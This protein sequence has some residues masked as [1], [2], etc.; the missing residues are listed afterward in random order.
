[1]QLV[2][3]I[4]GTPHRYLSPNRKNGTTPA[5][6]KKLI[7]AHASQVKKARGK[8]AKHTE[9]HEGLGLFRG[10]IKAYFP[11]TDI[12]LEWMVAWEKGHRIMDKDNLINMLKPYQDG[13]AD[14]LGI[15]DKHFTS[16]IH[17]QYRDPDGTGYLRLIITPR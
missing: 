1:M 12:H 6:R 17:S 2:V 16:E 5:A 9:E 8:A 3:D 11:N 13:V 10:I 14:A 15:N 7:M 4:P